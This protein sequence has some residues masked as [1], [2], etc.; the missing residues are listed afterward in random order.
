MALETLNKDS[1]VVV[2]NSDVEL[3]DKGV[4]KNHQ[5]VTAADLGGFIKVKDINSN[6]YEFSQLYID[7]LKKEMLG[8]DTKA[9]LNDNSLKIT[10]KNK[11]RV[12]ANTMRM[13]KENKIFKKSVFTLC[14]YRKN[15]KCPP[16]SIQASEMLHDKKKKK[17]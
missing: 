13:N 1:K 2:Y 6:S 16:W 4:R 9:F 10:K 3:A 14:D 17:R 11:P 15:D 12:F 7:T 5:G 8:T